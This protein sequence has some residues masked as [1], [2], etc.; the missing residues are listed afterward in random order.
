MKKL[1]II[2]AL[3]CSAAHS[4]SEVGKKYTYNSDSGNAI[5]SLAY[6]QN[7]SVLINANASAGTNSCTLENVK[8]SIKGN[9]IEAKVEGVESALSI[10]LKPGNRAEL[11]AEDDKICGLNA[12]ISGEYI[13][14]NTSQAASPSSEKSS[15]EKAASNLDAG[16]ATATHQPTV[17]K[18]SNPIINR[19][20][21]HHRAAE[22]RWQAEQQELAAINLQK[23]AGVNV[24]VMS[25][26][27][28]KISSRVVIYQF[29]DIQT[30]LDCNDYE[31][32]PLPGKIICL[33]KKAAQAH[34]NMQY[35][36]INAYSLAGPQVSGSLSRKFPA[37]IPLDAKDALDII[38][39]SQNYIKLMKKVEDSLK[40][41]PNGER[42]RLDLLK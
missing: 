23:T 18:I 39:A 5:L 17:L 38:A 10:I 19:K 11:D 9:K 2:S 35:A 25:A 33:N 29:D 3:I 34:I 24:P 20:K 16:K 14:K 6:L 26:P 22:I 12:Y 27:N 8:G 4:Q 21:P 40:I 41:D 1:L 30:L 15:A 42:L 32:F 13:L 7:S 36:F 28:H 37:R 31:D